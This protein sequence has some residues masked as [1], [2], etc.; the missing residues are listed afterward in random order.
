VPEILASV[1]VREA[2]LAA[3][4]PNL[5]PRLYELLKRC[6]DKNPKQRWQAVGDLRAEI[7]AIAAAP[8]VVA[9]PTSGAVRPESFWRRLAL[10]SAPAALLAAAAAGVGVWLLMR[11]PPPTRQPVRFTIAPPAA[12]PFNLQG[13]YRNLAISPDGTR[14]VYV[15]GKGDV[16]NNEGSELMVRAID[17]LDATPLRGI[18]TVGFPFISPDGRWVGFFSVVGT[19]GGELKKVSIAGGPPIT[20]CRY[21]GTARGASWGPDDTI[22]FATNDPNTGL[23][24]VPAVGGEPKVLT[25]PDAAHGEQDHLFPSLLP[26][27]RTVLFTISAVNSGNGTPGGLDNAQVAVL[28]LQTGQRKTLVRGGSD[29]EYVD[30]ST[31]SGPAPSAGSGQASSAGSGEPGYLVYASA[32]ALRAVR[33]DP[34]RLEVLSD[35]V[36]VVEQVTTLQTGAADYRISRQGTLVY[37]P[38]GSNAQGPTRS[39]VWVN[40]QGREEPINAPPRDYALPR[41]SPDGTR[42]ALDVRD[43]E[44]DI[45]IWDFMRQTLTRLTFDPSG[46]S[47]P[48]W[49]PDGRRVVF[50]SS[51]AGGPGLSAVTNLLWRAADGTGTVERLTTSPNPQLPHS[52]SPDGKSLLFQELNPKT[53]NDLML[54]RL[55]GTPRT[56]PPSHRSGEPGPPAQG[57]GGPG[58]NSASG[59]TA[60]DVRPLIQTTF[61]DTAGEISPDGRWLAYYSNES[62][63]NEVYVRPFPNVDSGRWQIS[64]GG[65]SRPAWAKNGRELFYFA[66]NTAMMAVAV[67]TTPSFSAGNPTKLFDGP[68][69]VTQ[70]GR[71][72]DVSRD[73]QRFL[74]IKDATA[75]N[76]PSALPTITVVL[77]WQEEL[78]QRVP[79]K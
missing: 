17:Q 54:L 11:Q 2:D 16:M 50:A 59:S 73:G 36:P 74:L 31:G 6:L 13:Y 35:P 1:L 18:T 64:T 70:S 49:T 8:Y 28:D 46:D 61:S 21:G 7:E 52:F 32:G 76:Q 26:G 63:R 39:L 57:F 34:A 12:Q 22:V 43:Q 42:V 55:D 25:K 33:F 47:W 40:R 62:G 37:V 20:L 65:G 78:K 67:R 24:S 5:N 3:L 27:G 23:F 29:A 60:S 71:T 45:W 48:I 15:A 66:P 69:S 68:W 30:P 14:L 44:N 58:P 38:G 4:P 56:G 53:N 19:G 9:A 51:Q 75:S 72:Y 77:N 41:L 79:I 10:F